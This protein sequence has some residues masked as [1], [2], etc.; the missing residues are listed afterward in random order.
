MIT[1]KDRI[2]KNQYY[3]N[4]AETIAERSTCLSKQYGA[5][6]VNNDEIIATGYNGA[7][8]G[9]INCCDIGECYRKKHDVKR[10]QDYTLCRS[11]HA[12]QNAIISASREKMLGGTLYLTG[13]DYRN[14]RYV[15]DANSCPICKRLIINSGIKTVIVRDSETLYREIPVQEWIDND[16]SLS[17]E[18]YGY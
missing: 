6:I 8:R 12:E 4:I 14:G 10:G 11:V 3:L 16:D 18:S 13:I 17:I 2:S 1:I 9:R 5:V 15:K 7:P